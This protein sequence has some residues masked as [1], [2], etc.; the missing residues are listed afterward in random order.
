MRNRSGRA[1]V[2]RSQ[3][4]PKSEGIGGITASK[5]NR[6]AAGAAQHLAAGREGGHELPTADVR[7]EAVT[8]FIVPTPTFR[9]ET[10]CAGHS[11]YGP[12]IVDQLDSTTVV[13]P[14]QHATVD[15]QGNLI[16]E[17]MEAES[18]NQM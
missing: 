6:L 2:E 4:A 16:I 3:F 14:G 15:R 8:F 1:S 7:Q 17:E 10:L 9:R 11:I 12:A 5:G 18:C 13:F